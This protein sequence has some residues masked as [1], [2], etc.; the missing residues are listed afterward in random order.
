[1]FLS[2]QGICWILTF[3]GFYA[4]V[5]ALHITV[6]G[7]ACANGNPAIQREGQRAIG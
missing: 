3:A 6:V 7:D 5:A 4:L 1:M 2:L